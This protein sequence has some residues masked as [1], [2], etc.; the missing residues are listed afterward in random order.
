MFC[1]NCGAEYR[2]GFTHC[3][4]CQVDLVERLPDEQATVDGKISDNLRLVPILET[5]NLADVINI[6]LLLDSEGIEYILQGDTMNF[7]RPVYP[8][9]LLVREDEADRVKELLKAIEL[10]YSSQNFIPKK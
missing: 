1:P 4:D 6:K 2:E 8:V 5:D 10:N 9:V 7:V 3:S